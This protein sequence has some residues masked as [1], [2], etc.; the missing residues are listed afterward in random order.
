M[1]G[2]GGSDDDFFAFHAL[3]RKMR[4]QKDAL[5]ATAWT[6]VGGLEELVLNDWLVRTLRV[7]GQ[8]V[9]VLRPTLDRPG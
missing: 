1:R 2:L 3:S 7:S 6:L 9:V 4:F 8:L 5:R